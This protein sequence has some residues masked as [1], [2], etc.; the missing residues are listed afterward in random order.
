MGREWSGR[1]VN[2]D[3][4]KAPSVEVTVNYEVG[5]HT[6]YQTS[7]YSLDY[8]AACCS[9]NPDSPPKNAVHFY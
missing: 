2:S 8:D 4:W 7:C 3:K 9:L 1:A 5:E 6:D